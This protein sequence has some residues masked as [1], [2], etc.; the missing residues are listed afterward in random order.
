MPSIEVHFEQDGHD[1]QG[2]N[3]YRCNYGRFGHEEDEEYDFS[4]YHAHHG[5]SLEVDP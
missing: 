5:D 3:Q 1:Y 4:H 2:E